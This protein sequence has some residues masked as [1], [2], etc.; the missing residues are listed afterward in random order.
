MGQAFLQKLKQTF[1]P[2]MRAPSGP[3]HP[4]GPGSYRTSEKEL[5]EQQL[6]AGNQIAREFARGRGYSLHPILAAK[7]AP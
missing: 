5:I 3:A 6:R 1:W 7:K 2:F 4:E